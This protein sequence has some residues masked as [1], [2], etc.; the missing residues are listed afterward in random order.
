MILTRVRSSLYLSNNSKDELADLL[1]KAPENEKAMLIA[2]LTSC[3]YSV[4]HSWR[5]NAVCVLGL[6]GPQARSAVPAIIKAMEGTFTSCK[7]VMCAAEALPKIGATYAVPELIKALQHAPEPDA[8][9]RR[10]WSYYDSHIV[11][12][13]EAFGPSA[14]DAA[15]YLAV[16]L[17]FH[18]SA[19]PALI[20]IGAAAVPAILREVKRTTAKRLEWM[21]F[22]AA[23]V[24]SAI[25]SDA[26]QPLIDAL[27]SSAPENLV[28]I[29]MVFGF[30]RLVPMPLRR[31]HAL[32]ANAVPTLQRLLMDTRVQKYAKKA[33]LTLESPP[34][35][36]VSANTFT[37][38]VLDTVRCGWQ[39]SDQTKGELAAIFDIAP[40]GK[41]R[42]LITPLT[43]SLQSDQSVERAN[44]VY[45]LGLLGPQAQSAVP[46][47]ISALGYINC[48]GIMQAA[49]ALR[50][51]GAAYAV[52]ELVNALPQP[53]SPQQSISNG[54][55]QQEKCILECLESF[56]PLLSS[57]ASIFAAFL[58][59]GG[60]NTVLANIGAAAI[61]AILNEVER[62]SGQHAMTWECPHA[63]EVLSA[64]GAAAS[65]PLI[66]ALESSTPQTR[67]AIAL[68]FG[69]LRG[70]ALSVEAAPVLCRFL[71]D[72]SQNVRT[73]VRKAL[74]ELGPSAAVAVGEH[75]SFSSAT[76]H[77]SDPSRIARD[78]LKGY[79]ASAVPALTAHMSS[80]NPEKQANL[81]VYILGIDPHDTNAAE[82]LMSLLGDENEK[83][84]LIA[85]H[86]VGE[87]C[88][89]A[90]TG[91]LPGLIKERLLPAVMKAWQDPKFSVRQQAA[92]VLTKIR[93][94]TEDL[95][96]TLLRSVTA[97]KSKLPSQ[98][99]SGEGDSASKPSNK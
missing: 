93:P 26:S 52:P 86:A 28:A 8:T 50:E 36:R 16:H 10:G 67:E 42:G 4:H 56:G 64:I 75:L 13:L 57:N 33:L 73:H 6:I 40:N 35:S 90:P 30:L 99:D 3:L 89:N 32:N 24:L 1:N 46:G 44:A 18:A 2:P 5:A 62:V 94:R 70:P 80:V 81:A 77:P 23:V 31:R 47:I 92:E 43:S 20:S 25:G 14:C 49:E 55:S 83:I 96:D 9:S 61:P 68:V 63:A 27:E 66:D 69:S 59:N 85:V 74:L 19:N 84:R 45:V 37:S 41:K 72:E 78:I 17:H 29:S 54:F 12:C 82:K 34:G 97:A 15:P 98:A 95:T 71:M 53:P 21:C 11:E 60:T 79:G 48:K 91:P 7:G 58:R 87:A 39:I 65:K 88:R 38:V 22:N 51:I 76:L